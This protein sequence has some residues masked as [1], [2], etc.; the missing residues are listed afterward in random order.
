MIHYGSRISLYDINAGKL[1][2]RFPAFK[3][4]AHDLTFTNGGKTLVT[5]DHRDGMVRLWNFETGNEERSFQ[6]VPE[7]EQ[8]QSNHVWR[9]V[10]APDGTT[11]AVAYDSFHAGGRGG[12][13]FRGTPHA[14]R[15]WDMASGKEKHTLEG[16][17]W[18]VVDMAFSPDG[19]LL[20]SASETSFS[21]KG[22]VFV[23]VA[24]TGKRVPALPDGL[25]LGA[26]A[27]AFSRDGRFLA[28]ALPDGAI[29]LWEVATWSKRNEFKGHR[30]R[31]TT[32]TFASGGQ[33][34]SGSLDTTV[35]AWDLRP[36]RVAPSVT[37]ESAWNDLARRDAAESFKSEGRFLAAPADTVKLF[38][39]RIKP[40]DAL[41][42][43]RVERLLADLG[44]NEFAVREAASKALA[45][46]DEQ[47]TCY[48]EDTL[49]S[50]ALAEVRVRVTRVLEQRRQAAI[51]ADQIRQIRAVMVLEWIGDGE[52]NDLLK[53]WGSGP[54]GA[55]LT[56]EAA[57]A[58]KRLESVSKVK[59]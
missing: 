49:K 29:Q 56:T 50:T 6:A 31:A 46:L 28:T 44:S 34:L 9:T 32:L 18:Y 12:L 7:A 13:G 8:S 38:A 33:L 16:H 54:V 43:K 36:P 21:E 53:R 41:D 5:V 17:H 25:R 22:P 57:A 48:L 35:L 11:V 52:A 47:A 4:D 19:R 37:L 51:T 58:L 30:D 39:E 55:R 23:W 45:E 26:T 2:D 14:V 15:L 42:P 1:V 40:V 20:A 3:G 27:V 59:R 10:L 24:A